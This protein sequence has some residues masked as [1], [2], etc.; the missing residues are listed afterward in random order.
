MWALSWSYLSNRESE[1]SR[2]GLQK[3]DFPC[4]VRYF[5]LT[6]RY[7]D[8][9]EE[10]QLKCSNN[11]CLLHLLKRNTDILTCPKEKKKRHSLDAS[12]ITP[13]AVNKK[14]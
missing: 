5:V 6:L 7:S 13:E 8:S 10:H 9:S 11:S 4:S 1:D 14:V 3:L 12:G 2:V